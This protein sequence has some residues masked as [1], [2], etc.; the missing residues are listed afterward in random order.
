MTCLNSTIEFLPQP[1]VHNFRDMTGQ[2][3]SRLTVL[4]I[5]EYRILTSGKRKPFWLC[6][7]ICG[8][9]TIVDTASLNNA[10]TRSCGCLVNELIGNLN[11]TH[12]MSKT[13]TYYSWLHMRGR[14]YDIKDPKYYRYG[15]RGIRICNHWLQSFENFLEDMGE[16]PPDRKSIERIDND[17]N[18]SCGHCEE[19]LN[20]RWVANC[21]WANI[22]EQANNKS[23]VRKFT[24]QGRTQTLP[25]WCRELH[26]KATCVHRRLRDGWSLE[27][28]LTMPT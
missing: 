7:C 16:K 14:C 18:Y 28:A 20:N 1:T 24:F 23:N 21:C 19:C 13:T 2:V 26:L 3:F 8:N 10:N 9:T 22:I 6:Q 27:R 12:G 4:G 15:E 11:R 5:I 25:Q 17:A